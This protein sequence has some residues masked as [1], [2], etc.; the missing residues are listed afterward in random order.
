MRLRIFLGVTLLAAASQAAAAPVTTS[1]KLDNLG[2]RPLDP[3]VVIF[4]ANPGATV[5]VRTPSN[6]V[7]F[8][9]P[10]SG[11]TIVAKGQDG[12]SSNDTVW[13]V[14]FTPFAVP[15]TYH[16]FSP[17]LNLQSYDFVVRGDAYR[18]VARAALKTFYYQRCSTPKPSAYAGSWSDAT[19]C[20]LADRTTGPAL[21]N[22]DRGIKDLTGGWHDAGDYNKYVWS[23]TSNAILF[24]LRAYEDQPAFRGDDL[25]VPESGN[26]T[27]DVLDEV[28]WELDWLLKMQ[29]ADGSVLRRTHVPTF[30]SD[31]PPSVDTHLRYYYDPDL[32]SGGVF[33]G[34]M[35]LAAR[36]YAAAGQAGYAA[37]L[38]A[39]ALRT[40]T[41]LATQGSDEFKVWAAAEIFRLDPAV[42]GTRAFVDAYHP[43][44][45][46]GVFF[47]VMAYDTQAAL[48]YV[49]APGATLAVVTQ[50][51]AN[52]A[53]QVDYIF[54][55]DDL[56][57]DGMPDWSYY[58]GSSSIRAGYGVFLLRAAQLGSTGSH[59]ADEC[60]RHA[61][62]FLHFFHGQN[63]LNM[64]Y[65]SNLSA[66]GGEH[67]SWQ[68][69]HSWFGYSGN[70]YSSANFIGK[71][72]AVSE[73]F[74]P[75]F[76]GV[77]NH[78]V[79]DNK[80]S[81]LG[82]PP[83]FVVGGPN[84]SYS[85]DTTPPLGSNGYN[86]F[87][88]DWCEQGVGDPRTWEI[89]ENSIGYQGPYAALA[90]AFMAAAHPLALGLDA[91]AS[92][93]SD[94]NHVFE[95]GETVT[96]A[97]VWRNATAATLGF[98]GTASSF[99]GPA[100]P[101]Y[102]IADAAA[103]YGPLAAGQSGG[104]GANCYALGV[105]GPRPATHWDATVRETVDT[106]EARTWTLHLA[107][108]FSDVPRAS[109]FYAFVETLL[110]KGV[111]GGCAPGSFCP[112]GSTTR[113]QMATF[114]LAA[115]EGS[116]YAPPACVAGSELFPDVPAGS[117][118]CRWIEELARRAVVG[119]CGGGS[120]CPD[121]PVSRAQVAVFVLASREGT[122]YVPP[123]C[124]TPLFSDVPPGS[125]FCRWVEE[126]VRR[127]VVS[128]CGGGQYCPD[129]PVTREQM[130]VFL[131]LTFGLALYGP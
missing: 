13:W 53:N 54:S 113:A 62:D 12:P 35:A 30:L 119:G 118:F 9:V 15:G 89:T 8:T 55:S 58:W 103:A 25:G 6:T 69:Y 101:T 112:A 121:A 34:T 65:L 45:W 28:K 40:W 110:H 19:A 80:A 115:K 92:G 78:G 59:S 120:Y 2:Y 111:T 63:A 88:R 114:V 42:N 50:M 98:S 10:T 91:A 72:A 47:N 56:Y 108:S 130:S 83:G 94:G 24:L 41:W 71:P 32:E 122:G 73:P 99:M 117:P 7:V 22:T 16:L 21:G 66:L 86:R 105:S 46:G 36:V 51:R 48:T 49:Q 29:L 20:H 85:G 82:P 128:G 1:I 61:L 127:G 123:A 4:T 68:F 77:D 90:A 75:Y 57:R 104:C 124:T 52:V 43:N 23:A 102:T 14:D 74:Y 93:S 64:A 96:V 100:G 5:Q 79:N 95:P 87:Y 126:M 84:T 116:G 31:S 37:T 11:G 81:A 17:S 3:K 70:A 39:A 18:D 125:P 131:A 60:R 33:A 129:A 44:N 26:G 97:P 109:P 67:S 106:G 107:D 27:P 38:K 76:A